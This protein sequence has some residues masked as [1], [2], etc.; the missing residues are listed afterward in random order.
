MGIQRRPGK[1]DYRLQYEGHLENEYHWYIHHVKPL[2]KKLFNKE[3]SVIKKP[4]GTVSIGFRSKGVVTF[5]RNCC[6]IPLSPKKHIAV[7]QII[8]GS[9]DNIKTSFLRGLA[10]TDFSLVF[11]K[12]GKYPVIN[13]A[14]YSKNLHESM[15]L[16]LTSLGFTYYSKT[17]HRLRK[18]TEI[19]SHQIDINGKKKLNQWISIVGFSG[20]NTLTRYLVWK[21]TGSLPVGTNL[22]ER[23]KILKN[24][25]IKIPFH[26]PEGIRTL[27]L[28]VNSRLL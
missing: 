28:S 5:L 6:D 2:I 20:Y 18:G 27:D 7:P 26:G 14:T 10:D 22:D 25:G 11:K 24:Q 12:N 4:R 3:V 15:K 19:Q 13:Y 9:C 17:Y 16:L 1:V 23:I 8:A 21:E